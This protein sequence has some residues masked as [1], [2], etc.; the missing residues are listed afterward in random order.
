MEL[1]TLE[2]VS[3]ACEQLFPDKTLS[4]FTNFPPEELSLDGQWEVAISGIS[5]HQCTKMLRRESS[6]FLRGNFQSH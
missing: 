2:L 5:N 6:C 4:S 3:N 1:F